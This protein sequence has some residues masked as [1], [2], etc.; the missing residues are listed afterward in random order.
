MIAL[1]LQKLRKISPGVMIMFHCVP[2]LVLPP[3][4]PV[5]DGGSE[6]RAKKADLQTSSVSYNDHIHSTLPGRFSYTHEV[7][8]H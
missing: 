7:V 4:E 3:G 1:Y 2:Q 8:I 5:E 6:V